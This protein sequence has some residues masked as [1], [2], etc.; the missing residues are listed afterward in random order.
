MRSHCCKRRNN[1]AISPLRVNQTVPRSNPG[2]V[3][4][5]ELGRKSMTGLSRFNGKPVSGLGVKLA[6][7]ANEMVATA[8]LVLDRSTSWRSTSSRAGI[9]DRVCSP[10]LSKPS[11]IDVVKTLLEAIALVFRVMYLFLQKLS[12]HADS[13]R[14]PCR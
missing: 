5:V 9:Q 13:G 6:S 4:T 8:K 2:D 10:P 7:G 14:S 12:R 1:F 3:A 11:I